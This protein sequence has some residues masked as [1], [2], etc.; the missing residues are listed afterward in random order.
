MYIQP[1]PIAVS[2]L[3]SGIALEKISMRRGIST[4]FSNTFLLEV[5][6]SKSNLDLTEPSLTRFCL[7]N[8]AAFLRSRIGSYVS[9]SLAKFKIVM[10]TPIP[11]VM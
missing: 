6:E 9:L 3:V 2:P 10:M 4:A 8:R 5:F 7:R 1:Y 11:P